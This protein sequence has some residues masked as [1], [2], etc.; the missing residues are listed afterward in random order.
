MGNLFGT[1]QIKSMALRNRFVRSATVDNGAESGHVSEKQIKSFMDLS[2]GG[3]GLIVT[4][5][6]AVHPSDYIKPSQNQLSDDDCIPAYKRL[7]SAVHKGGAK[8]AIQL[9]HM[10]RE[11]GKFL[12]DAADEA[13]GPS[14]I[15]ND[16][17]CEAKKYRAMT[18][19][20]IREIIEAFGNAA[21][22]ARETGF[23]AVQIHGAHAFLLAQFLSPYT[24]RR[25]DEW[26]GSLENR[27][28]IHTE[29]YRAI[30]TNVGKDYPVL[31]KLGVEDGF[32]GGLE[33]SEGKKAAQMLA[34]IGFDALEISQGLR[35]E[36]FEGTEFRTR[37][38]GPDREAYFR[39]WGKEVKQSVNVPVMMVGGLR[40]PALMTEIIE[41]GEADFI[42]LCRPF[43]R[44]PGI[45]NEWQ[46][47]DLRRSRC[48]SCNKCIEALKNG[49][50]LYCP[51][52]KIKATMQEEGL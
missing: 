30:R 18:T 32:S 33:F 52:N 2:D 13:I 24:N 11:R 42:S 43:I 31:I 17:Y 9:A 51:Q 46:K 38:D 12:N 29:I 47:G 6:T 48:V 44:E 21:K 27:L 25:D 20:E 49:E 16:P 15:E 23:D 41:K 39:A 28:R 7:T 40:T 37:I 19:D 26:G 34:Q 1:V 5:M 4:G 36:V 45:V 14:F 35:G 8:I 3:I 50:F 10:G 22:R